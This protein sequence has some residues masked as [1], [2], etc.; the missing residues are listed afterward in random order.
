MFLTHDVST[1]FDD[2]SLGIDVE[3]RGNKR[4][5]VVGP[6][7]WIAAVSVDEVCIVLT[8]VLA[9]CGILPPLNTHSL[10]APPP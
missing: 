7:T 2:Y 9:T 10:L 6:V 1:P 5:V 4:D 8:K 3:N